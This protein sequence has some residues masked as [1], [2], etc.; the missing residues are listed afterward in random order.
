MFFK[1]TVMDQ[2]VLI[3]C[4]N[5]RMC[6]HFMLILCFACVIDAFPITLQ[7]FHGLFHTGKNMPVTS[8][9]SL[10]IK[11]NNALG[12]ELINTAHL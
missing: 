1:E 2:S 12:A 7:A 4:Q 8:L 9:C 5:L 11:S 6:K 3:Y 10:C